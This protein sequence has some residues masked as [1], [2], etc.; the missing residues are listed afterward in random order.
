MT[1]STQKAGWQHTYQTDIDLSLRAL[2]N[3]DVI[4]LPTDT[5]WSL[6]CDATNP[7]AARHLLGIVKARS[8]EVGEILTTSLEMLKQWI[9]HLH[10]RL[11][12]L[13]HYHQRPLTILVEAGP[14]FGPEVCFQPGKAALRISRDPFC[15]HL[16]QAFG[17][18]IFTVF[19]AV[20]HQPWPSSFGSISSEI[21]QHC[22][23]VVRHRQMERNAGEPSVMVRL[24]PDTEELD[25]LRD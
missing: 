7:A 11:E 13:L 3:G 9:P 1:T 23:H 6:G 5:L 24:N 20:V 2:H 8:P 17:K 10:P 16:L 25:F 4:L 14:K 22:A 15:R 19:A 12:T 21:I 18:P